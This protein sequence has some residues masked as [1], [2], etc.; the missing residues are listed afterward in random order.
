MAY[1]GLAD[2]LFQNF[3]LFKNNIL[4]FA[5]EKLKKSKELTTNKLLKEYLQLGSDGM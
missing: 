3:P 5:T 1:P 4:E 2:R